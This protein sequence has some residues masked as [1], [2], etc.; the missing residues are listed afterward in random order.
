MNTQ[1]DYTAVENAMEVRFS[2]RSGSFVGVIRGS[3]SKRLFDL[4]IR[5]E[6]G[7]RIA[8]LTEQGSGKVVHRIILEQNRLGGTLTK[9]GKRRPHSSGKTATASLAVWPIEDTSTEI[10]VVF[11]DQDAEAE[12]KANAFWN[13]VEDDEAQQ[14]AS[15]FLNRGMEL[16]V[17]LETSEQ[18]EREMIEHTKLL[19]NG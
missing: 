14:M 3:R 2:K 15:T 12:E 17:G 4:E 18:S 9:A 7:S 1:I 10:F 11:T 6:S 13:V 8:D 16:Q 5:M 19:A